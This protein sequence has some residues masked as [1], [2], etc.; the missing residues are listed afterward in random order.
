MKVNRRTYI[1]KEQTD[2][3]IKYFDEMAVSKKEERQVI[4]TYHSEADFRLIKTKDY[5]TLDLKSNNDEDVV[6]IHKKYEKSMI[7]ILTHIGSYVA[8]KRFRTRHMYRYDNMYITIDENLK[9]GNVFRICYNS[10]NQ[11]SDKINKIYEYFNIEESGMD[12]FEELYSK[13][14]NS[15]ADLTK[16][17]D[18]EEFLNGRQY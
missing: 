4:Y 5:I 18:E 6:F 15:W 7:N 16:E 12:K 8:V 9:Y 3:L 14:R 2:K 1:N 13:Y 11:V 10:D 17:I